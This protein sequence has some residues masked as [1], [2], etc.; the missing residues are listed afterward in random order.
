M[1]RV[2]IGSE[3][4]GDFPQLQE[5]FLIPPKA[6]TLEQIKCGFLDDQPLKAEHAFSHTAFGR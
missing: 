1:P 4:R 2:I 5:Q 3:G 6:E